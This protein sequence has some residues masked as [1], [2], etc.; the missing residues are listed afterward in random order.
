MDKSGLTTQHS[1]PVDRAVLFSA[2]QKPFTVLLES[3]R[4]DEFNTAH[5]LFTDPV[6]VLRPRSADD[7]PG[8]F[9]KIESALTRRQ[10]I[11]GYVGYECGYHFEQISADVR[12]D[13]ELPLM[14]LCVYD[15]P[16]I[17]PD[18]ILEEPGD[19]HDFGIESSHLSL[20][21]VDYC[22][23]I[24]RIKEYIVNGDT[25][26]VNFTDRI[27]F[28]HSGDAAG[29]YRTLRERQHV[30]FGAYINL[31]DRQI[32]SFSPELFFRRHGSSITA[33]PMK[34][35]CKRGRTVQEDRDL[36]AWLRSDVKN[37]SENLMIVDLLRNDLGR[38][39]MA[40]SVAVT[41]LYAVEQLETVL[42]MTSTVSGTLRNEVGYY[43]IFRSLFPCGSVTGAP[44][45][46]TMQIIRELEK[47]PRGVYCGSIGYISPSHDAVF[48]VAI[49]T[50]VVSG[51]RCV[52]GV[53][54]GIVFDSDSQKEYDECL[55]KT[56]FVTEQPPR[57]ELLETILW[58]ESY[59]FLDEH[60]DRMQESADYF[61]RP[62]DRAAVLRALHAA[63]KHF[64]C[65]QEYRVRL[66]AGS[67][68]KPRTEHTVLQRETLPSVIKIADDRTDSSDR[69]IFH[70]TTMR[71]LYDRYRKKAQNESIADFIFLNERNEVTEGTIT[72]IFIEKKQAYYTPPVTAGILNGIYRRRMLSTLRPA[73]ERTL[74]VY[75]LRSAD[76]IYLCNSVRGWRK[77]V[78]S[79]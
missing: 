30:P 22:R 51:N 1:H 75:D 12:H 3:S 72:N 35:T 73:Q 54:S 16:L 41:D 57:F 17:V 76:A 2:L 79:E 61:G 59:T 34:G 31:G 74:T 9:A 46:R 28:N 33:K 14:T 37:T 65:R 25:Y 71:P 60:L 44:K 45:I 15:Q 6:E 19:E 49:R 26:Q 58:K 8:L 48:S 21:E 62:F 67:R 24:E 38:I 53:G 18:G 52:M 36:A 4:R 11:A 40:G 55:L 78:L 66:L 63:E 32:L 77:V 39:C 10:W 43:E 42:Q 27:E 50:L 20:S 69:F 29:L 47:H 7:I 64:D 13:P 56:R 23:T 70:K 68:S 5:Y